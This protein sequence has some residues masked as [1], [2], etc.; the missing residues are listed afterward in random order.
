[1][2]RTAVISA[3]L[4]GKQITV[5]F[6]PSLYLDKTPEIW[7]QQRTAGTWGWGSAS[8]PHSLVFNIPMSFSSSNLFLLLFLWEDLLVCRPISSLAVLVSHLQR[9]PF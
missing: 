1:M 6:S 9:K 5:G 8:A 2:T 7:L 4:K 3:K